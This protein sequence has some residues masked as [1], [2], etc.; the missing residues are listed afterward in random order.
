MDLGL[1]YSISIVMLFVL[2]RVMIKI[3]NDTYTELISGLNDISRIYL[4]I[5]SQGS[6]NLPEAKRTVTSLSRLTRRRKA[7]TKLGSLFIYGQLAFIAWLL[8]AD[9]DAVPIYYYGILLL[10]IPL[11]KR[12]DRVYSLVR[13]AFA[14]FDDNT[15][16]LEAQIQ[17]YEIITKNLKQKS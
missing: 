5:A 3:I 7:L 17:Q 8:A 2:S 10:T 14:D 4:V 9:L 16:K 1:K 11:L 12:L 6:L 13:E 15:R